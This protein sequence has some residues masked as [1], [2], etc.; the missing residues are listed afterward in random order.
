VRRAHQEGG[1]KRVIPF[2]R[3][4]DFQAAV[5]ELAKTL[6]CLVYHTHD[7]RRSEAGFPDLV[8]VGR[9]GVIFRE[10]KTATG[11]VTPEQHLWVTFLAR[12]GANVAVWRPEDWPNRVMHEVQ[13][14]A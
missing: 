14:I 4:R 10:L 1:V 11:R 3:E 9:H 8:I 2:S 5:C 13:A 12:G 7:S 6:G